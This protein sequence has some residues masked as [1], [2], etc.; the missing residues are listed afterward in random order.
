MA[1]KVFISVLGTGF[2]GSCKY[3]EVSNK[4]ES[5]DTRFIQTATLEYLS[6]KEW[7]DDDLILILLTKQ[8]RKLTGK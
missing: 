3:N 1:R 7:Q 5:S 8:S 6:A 4:F 2:Y